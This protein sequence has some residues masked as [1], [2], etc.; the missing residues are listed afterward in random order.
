MYYEVYRFWLTAL[1]RIQT[2]RE[3]KADPKPIVELGRNRARQRHEG[4]L[5]VEPPFWKLG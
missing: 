4:R 2:V 3:R 1:R 5:I